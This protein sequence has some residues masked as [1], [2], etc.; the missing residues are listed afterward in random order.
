MT[1]TH[2]IVEWIKNVIEEFDPSKYG[3]KQQLPVDI[4]N[5][6]IS[7]GNEQMLVRGYWIK[8]RN[9]LLKVFIYSLYSVYVV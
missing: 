8:K 6:I 3:K 9:L 7:Y 5:E 2:K 4:P 1:E